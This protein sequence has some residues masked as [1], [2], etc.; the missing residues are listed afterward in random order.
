MLST[1][2]Y[3]AL[4]VAGTLIVYVLCLPYGYLLS[5][6]GRE[7]HY[8]LFE[9]IPGFVWGNALSMAWGGLFVGILAW[10]GGWY[11]AWM[12]NASMVSGVNQA[13]RRAA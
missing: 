1:A 9:L 4:C 2:K 5:D 3:A 8:A 12:H 10:I 13:Q 6:K 7:L 11:I